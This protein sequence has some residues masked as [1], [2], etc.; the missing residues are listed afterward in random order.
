MQEQ[1]LSPDSH[2][3]RVIDHKP[4]DGESI[5]MMTE[6][7]NDPGTS[8]HDVGRIDSNVDENDQGVADARTDGHEYYDPT[9]TPDLEASLNEMV[10]RLCASLDLFVKRGSITL[11]DLFY[12]K[13]TFE[14]STGHQYA[15][16]SDQ[17]M[18]WFNLERGN[19]EALNSSKTELIGDSITHNHLN[20]RAWVAQERALSPAVIHFTPEKIWWEC[21]EFVVNE[22]FTGGRFSW[23]RQQ[24]HKPGVI[25][26][27]Q[28]KTREEVYD[29]W[30]EFISIY[31]KT[32]LTFEKDRFPA[33]IGIAKIV[34]EILNDN[35]IAGF[36]EGDLVRSL[37]W[38]M[39]RVASVS[40]FLTAILSTA[41]LIS[42][43]AAQE[44]Q[45]PPK[46]EPLFNTT[47]HIDPKQYGPIEVPGGF[48]IVFNVLN[49]TI[50][51]ALNAT[52]KGGVVYPYVYENGTI[53]HVEGRLWGTTHDGVD[54]FMEER[55][56]G[57]AERRINRQ[58]S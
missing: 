58:A 56:I 26:H 46:I 13:C 40:P 43:V 28:Q 22:A 54:F 23:I 55:G 25:R 30:T 5:T 33:M 57:G 3:N 36:W 41:A 44:L 9:V 35:F 37:V 15:S 45:P 29:F 11:D 21:N 6:A 32:H 39:D 1:N 8:I 16:G 27:L 4:L 12:I 24:C 17:V 14:N 18:L 7:N 34:G 42:Q 50:T 10:S 53:Q 48:Q 47:V 19:H 20:S 52:I 38:Q 31:V 49:A 51:G 2:G